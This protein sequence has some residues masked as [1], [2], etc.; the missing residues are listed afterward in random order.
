MK[1]RARMSGEL[2]LLIAV[3]INSMG[4]ALMSKSHFGISPISSV[5][6]VLSQAFPFVSFGTWNYAFQ[7]LLIVILMILNRH[8]NFSCFF[9]FLIG[10]AFGK[11]IDVHE[12]WIQRLPDTLEFHMIYFILS[13]L[14]FAIGICLSNNSNLPIIPTDIFTRDLSGIINK[15]YKK[16]K[17]SFDILCLLTTLLTSI[18]FL[19]KIIGVGIGTV[20]CAMATGKAVSLVQSFFD[21]HLVFYNITKNEKLLS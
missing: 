11:M 13:F 16:V 14:L 1:N 2:A 18:L 6:Y 5:P 17:T 12:L 8:L 21:K 7:T 20:L 19:H 15:A 3:V 4:V 10:I 9:S